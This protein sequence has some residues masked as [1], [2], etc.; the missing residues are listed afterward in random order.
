MKVHKEGTGLLL[1]LFTVLFV[2]NVALYHTVGKG[3]LFYSVAT[4]STI[5][6][7][8]ILNFFRSPFR[9]FP[10]D[11]EGLVI[12][13]ADG[14]IVAIEEVMENEI[15]HRKCLQISIFMSVFNV[16][17]NWFPVNGTVK[18]VSHNNGRFMAAYLPKSS[19]ENERS[20]VVITTKNGVDVLARQIA[21]ALARRIVTYAKVG[22]KCHVDEQMGFIKFGSRV[23]VY[24]P[25]GTEVL[26]EMD[27]KVTGNQTPIA[28]LSKC[29]CE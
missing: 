22:E 28:R 25:V 7:L 2:V 8:L 13:P 4:V 14:T 15:L 18:H 10:Y 29:P 12:A 6:F 26:I 3:V 11:S 5:L 16:H 24:L 19:T 1:T 20:A 23:D 21:G 17:A 27:Q 9:R